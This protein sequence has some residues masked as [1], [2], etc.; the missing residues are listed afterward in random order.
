MA[1][2]HLIVIVVLQLAAGAA[3]ACLFATRTPPQGW[4]EWSS[5]LF[6]GDVTTVEQD[7]QKTLDVI[8]VRVVETFKGPD[9]AGAVTLT[10]RLSGRYWA[11]CKVEKPPV[12]ARVLVAM[13]ANSDAM[14]VPLS[15]AFAQDLRSYK[16]RQL[17]PPTPK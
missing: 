4:F 9:A 2:R 12:G 14:L 16:A 13:N 11:N 1:V 5:G 7:G 3:N 6:A 17:Q 15:A 8:T 10:V